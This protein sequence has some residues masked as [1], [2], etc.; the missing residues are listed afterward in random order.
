MTGIEANR[1]VPPAYRTE[2]MVDASV[3]AVWRVVADVTRTSEWS[4]ECH[5]VTWLRGATAAAPGARFRGHNRSGRLR[6][7]RVCEIVALEAPC[8]ISW[9]TIA[10]PLFPDSTVWSIALEP[11]GTG[12]RVVQTYRTGDPPRWFSWIVGKLVPAHLDRK[13]ALA[14]DLR[15]IG[16]IAA[17]DRHGTVTRR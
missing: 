12:T 4:H 7:S 8:L 3:E 10:T 11:V 16:T 5:R 9:R 1:G 14:D 13:G 6:W 2:V 17:C 15:R